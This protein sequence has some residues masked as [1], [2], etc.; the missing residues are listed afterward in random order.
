[1]TSA[2][3][4]VADLDGTLLDADAR[5]TA[6]TRNGLER[7]LAAGV[8]FS[9][10]TARSPHSIRA[11]V[12]NLPL[13]LPVIALHGALLSDI[14]SGRHHRIRSVPRAVTEAV[15]AIARRHDTPPWVSTH[16]DG[17]DRLA[18]E[19]VTNAGMQWYLDD[20]ARVRDPRLQWVERLE[21]ALSGDVVCITTMGRE[22]QTQA[23]ADDVRREVGE[24]VTVHVYENAYS[25]GWI[26]MT[27]H[28]RDAGKDSG[29]RDLVEH[30]GLHGREIVAFGDTDG[31][32]ALFAAA[33]RGVAVSNASSALLRIAD[34]TIGAHTDDA[35][36]DYMLRDCGLHG[37]GL[38]D[39]ADRG[40]EA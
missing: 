19:A 7:M 25:P 34:E 30:A 27:A 3:V 2:P 37:D 9:I 22:E 36:I 28:A 29:L 26:W 5:L 39:S 33:D 6:R 12:G 13:Q 1:M 11:I 18:Y 4:Y 31:D 38:G 8:T 20:R 17:A 40:L 32:L 10:A 35:V 23:V 21:S 15:I 24:C 16:T 14:A